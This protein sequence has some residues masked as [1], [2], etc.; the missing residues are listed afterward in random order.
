MLILS[1]YVGLRKTAKR[2][3]AIVG[4]SIKQKETK[5]T[6]AWEIPSRPVN[7]SKDLRFLRY[8]LLKL[9]SA[10]PVPKGKQDKPRR[11]WSCYRSSSA[12]G[13]GIDRIDLRAMYGART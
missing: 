8:L 6:K 13:V 4:S 9:F 5:V 2:E 12:D 3:V 7:V 1:R 10:R 11:D